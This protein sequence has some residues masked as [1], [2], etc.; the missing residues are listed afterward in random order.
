MKAVRLKVENNTLNLVLNEEAKPSIG[1]RDVLVRVRAASLNYRDQAILEDNYPGEVKQVIPVSDGAGE[2]VAVG[3]SVTRAKVG[4][5]VSANCWEYWIGGPILPEYF[6]SSVGFTTDGWL[7]E[8]IVLNEAAIVH[9]PEYLS[10][11]DA[12]ALPCA[13]VTAWAAL[14]QKTPLSPGQTVLVQGT[15]GVALFALQIAKMVGARVLAITSSDEK[16]EKLKE[17]GAEAVVNY[18]KQPN[19]EKDILALTGGVGVDK[20]VDIAGEKTIVKSAASTRIGGNV[21]L[22]GFAGGSGGGI[23]PVDIMSRALSLNTTT[24]GTRMDFEALLAAMTAHKMKPVIDRIFPFADY[25]EAYSR[26]ASGA[27]VGKIVIEM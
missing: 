7:A 15:G 2:V 20:V 19:W 13:A 23:S 12:A 6:S 14:N 9:L 25:Q 21:A 17:L 27:M 22:V 24:M 8:Y 3:D 10:F 18:T 16:A 26:L 5:R 4:D 1:R 11:T